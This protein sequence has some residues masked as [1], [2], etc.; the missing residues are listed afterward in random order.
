MFFQKPYT[1]TESF[2]RPAT[3]FEII[4]RRMPQPQPQPK[5]TSFE[6]SRKLKS[7]T[8]SYLKEKQ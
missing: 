3:Q 6:D 8:K 7:K 1:L 4:D 5:E 2:N